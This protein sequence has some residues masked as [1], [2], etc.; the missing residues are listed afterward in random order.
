MIMYQADERN[1]VRSNCIKYLEYLTSLAF[2][3][4]IGDLTFVM[5]GQTFVLHDTRPLWSEFETKLGCAT[6]LLPF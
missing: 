1:K 5:S 6:P 4:L 2:S 3:N